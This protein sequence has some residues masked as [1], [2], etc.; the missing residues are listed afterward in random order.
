MWT[1]YNMG[2]NNEVGIGPRFH[3]SPYQVSS[4]GLAEFCD[5]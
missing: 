5:G 4:D 1:M 3:E 2:P